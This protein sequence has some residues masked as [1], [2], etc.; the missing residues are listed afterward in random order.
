MKQK[1]Q[2]CQGDDLFDPNTPTFWDK[3]ISFHKNNIFKS[4]IYRHKNKLVFHIIKKIKGNILDIGVGYGFI[5]N[6]ILKHN[7]SLNIYGIDISKYAIQT[8]S[9]RIE[10]T[11]RVGSVL[12]IPFKSNLFDV[13]LVLDILEHISKS[14]IQNA[15]FEIYRV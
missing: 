4:P 5:E 10:G 8:V 12:K 6:L 14:N 13:I 3:K 9:K 11:F 1:T 7:L 15:L 2:T